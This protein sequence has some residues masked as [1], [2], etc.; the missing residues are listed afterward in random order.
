MYICVYGASSRSLSPSL[1][2]AAETLGETMA[3]RGHA[4]VFGAG[5]EGV[6]G[7]TAR[8]VYHQGGEILGVAPEFFNADGV[9]FPHCT[10][11]FR[12]DTM[13]ERKALLQNLSDAFVV[14]PGGFGTYD[15]AFEILTLKQLDRHNK[16]VII[17][18]PEG[19]YDGLLSFFDRGIAEGIMK[20]A[21]KKLYTVCTTPDEVVTSIETYVPVE[22]A[23]WELK[24]IDLLNDD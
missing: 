7:A 24:D 3:S 11:L 21:S 8:G 6:M 14:A 2:K 12:T 9:L 16:P 19:F 17:F 18:N 23:L 10:R 1:I 5:N 13:R 22:L 15:E 4:L 20:D